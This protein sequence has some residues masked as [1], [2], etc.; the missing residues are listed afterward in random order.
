MD[1]GID[2]LLI[3]MAFILPGFLTSR[4]VSARTPSVGRETSTFDETS[5]SL[6]RSVYINFVSGVLV[7]GVFFVSACFFRVLPSLQS[8]IRLQGFV[9]FL[10]THLDYL[11]TIVAIWLAGSFAVAVFFGS[12]W[13]PLDILLKKLSKKTGTVSEDPLYILRQEV[14]DLRGE[15]KTNSQLWIQVRLKNSGIYQ[16]EF[17]FAGYRRDS[18]SREVLLTHVKYFPNNSDPFIACDYV[19]LDLA[20]SESVEAIIVSQ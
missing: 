19:F 20:N 10:N 15:G 16:G 18:L 13:D 3:A 4:L 5:E 7:F 14:I 9:G 6:L 2:S 1:F 11:I 17:V 8:Q 12:K